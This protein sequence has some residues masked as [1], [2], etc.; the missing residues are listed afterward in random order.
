MNRPF[1]KSGLVGLLVIAMSIVLLNVFPTQAP[2]MIDGFFTPIIAFEFIQTQQ[3]VYQLFGSS[4]SVDRQAMIEAMDLGNW[5]DF[6]YMF[7]YSS[8]LLLFSIR[9]GKITKKRY[10][11][12]GVILSFIVLVADALENVQLLRITSEI[13]TQDFG[14]ALSY[15]HFF[16]WVK[17]G[18]IAIIFLVLVPYFVKGNTYS[19][20]MAIAGIMS[21]VLGTLSYIHRSVLNEIFALSVGIMFL[22]MIIYCF[23]YKE[24]NP[25]NNYN[26][27]D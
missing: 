7:L 2:S 3:E 11:Q 18:S 9:C 16:T 13:V 5:L 15:L 19:K 25:T 22:L 24:E 21:F 17:W 8:F 14:K 23:I 10:Y 12:A 6:I 4:D 1:I 26:G 20:A 27:S